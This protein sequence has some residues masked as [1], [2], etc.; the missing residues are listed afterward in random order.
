MQ[1]SGVCHTAAP[2]HRL[3]RPTHPDTSHEGRARCSLLQGTAMPF[4][5]VHQP[6]F[7]PGTA[8]PE[9][10]TCGVGSVCPF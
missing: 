3:W 8:N 4:S 7:Y 9:H 6:W 2:Q 1:P 10:L 5:W